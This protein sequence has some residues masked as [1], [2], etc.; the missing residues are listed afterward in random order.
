M[1]AFTIAVRL[2]LPFCLPF[3]IMILFLFKRTQFCL[4]LDQRIAFLAE[5][6]AFISVHI[7]CLFSSKMVL[8]ILILIAENSHSAVPTITPP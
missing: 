7:Y 1:F 5:P 6:Q 3:K 8:V 2:L 4:K